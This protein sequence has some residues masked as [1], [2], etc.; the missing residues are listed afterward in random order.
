MKEIICVCKDVER[1]QMDIWNECKQY[2]H[3]YVKVYANASSGQKW[4][5]MIGQEKK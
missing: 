2:M 3:V 5:K 4:N 1:G